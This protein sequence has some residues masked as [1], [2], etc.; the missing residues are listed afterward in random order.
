MNQENHSDLRKRMY[1][2]KEHKTQLRFMDYY[3]LCKI[4]DMISTYTGDINGYPVDV[5]KKAI[6]NELIFR[7]K[8]ADSF[9]NILAEKVFP[10]G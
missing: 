1:W 8:T 9:L 3:H 4:R 2:G 6:N 7:N 10:A 5:W